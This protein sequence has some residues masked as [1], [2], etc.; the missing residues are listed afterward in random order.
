MYISSHSCVCA[1]CLPVWLQH[2]HRP[3]SAMPAAGPQV[4]DCLEQCLKTDD[5][6]GVDV[7]RHGNDNDD[8]ETSYCH[9]HTSH[10]ALSALSRDTTRYQ[11]LDRCYTGRYVPLS[12][13]G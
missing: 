7:I 5:C 4:A 1:A 3:L 9:Y 2:P 6:I 10:Q 11:L 13:R 12:V 8:D